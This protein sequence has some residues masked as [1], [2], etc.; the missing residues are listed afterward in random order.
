MIQRH[1]LL[2]TK[3]C[4]M[5]TFRRRHLTD[6]RLVPARDAAPDSFSVH[7]QCLRGATLAGVV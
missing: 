6:C 2:H 1:H 7:A 5:L 3:L 4:E